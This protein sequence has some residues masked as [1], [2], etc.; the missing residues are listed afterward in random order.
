M[1]WSGAAY[2]VCYECAKQF[3]P[4]PHMVP[5]YAAENGRSCTVRHLEYDVVH[6]GENCAE[7]KAARA[8]EEECQRR[9]Y[10]SRPLN[11]DV[12]GKDRMRAL[13]AAYR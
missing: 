13:T 3:N 7:C 10:S 11:L 9:I 6:T 12:K 2:N 4:K 5:C 8:A 1:C